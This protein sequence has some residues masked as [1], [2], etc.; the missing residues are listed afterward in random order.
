MLS[1]NSRR[2]TRYI[3]DKF[4]LSF[5]NHSYSFHVSNSPIL[6]T[7]GKLQ[8]VVNRKGKGKVD[9][10][11]DVAFLCSLQLPSFDLGIEY[12]QPNDL[13]SAEIQKQVDAIISD[14]ITTSKN[15]D[16]EVFKLF[17]LV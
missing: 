10:T 12:T 4:D 1:E 16:E 14:V 2:S 15:I 11:D 5:T 8:H 7:G 9:P 3:R 6:Q 17:F 13:Q